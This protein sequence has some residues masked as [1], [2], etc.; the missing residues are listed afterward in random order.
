MG[1]A[2][3]ILTGR[4][5]FPA[6]TFAFGSLFTA[7]LLEWNSRRPPQTVSANLYPSAF[8]SRRP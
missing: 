4:H 2:A 8:P 7:L 3:L 1:L 5:S 6:G